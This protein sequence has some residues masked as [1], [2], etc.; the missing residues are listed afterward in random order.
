[1]EGERQE[2]LLGILHDMR[3]DVGRMAGAAERFVVVAERKAVSG[4]YN[5]RTSHTQNGLLG[6]ILQLLSLQAEAGYSGA[7]GAAKSFK[8]AEAGE[9]GA[10]GDNAVAGPSRVG[11]AG[12]EDRGAEAR[13][14]PED[15]EDEE[16]SGEEEV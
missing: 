14:A 11:G 12:Y 9:P 16:E 15:G 13:A 1:M 3:R 7:A 6:S 10:A 2:D 5:V 8:A 4:E